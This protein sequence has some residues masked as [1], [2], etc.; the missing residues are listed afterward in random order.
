MVR[1]RRW[2]GPCPSCG[3]YFDCVP[4]MIDEETG[5]D[6]AQLG[7]DA[8][9]FNQVKPVELER[10]STGLPGFDRL[11]GEDRVSGTAGMACI[12]GHTVQIAG[13]PGSGKTTLLL[14]CAQG[15]TRS[16]RTGLYIATEESKE[17]HAAR[18]ERLGRFSSRFIMSNE[19]DLDEIFFIIE[20]Y[21]PE[22]VWVDS[23]NK[24]RLKEYKPGSKAAL[25][26]AAEDLYKF[27]Y[28]KGFGLW[29]VLQVDKSGTDF[30]GPKEIEHTVD[31]SLFM[32]KRGGIR[33]RLLVEKNRYGTA[34][35]AWQDYDLVKDAPL[36]EVPLETAADEQM[37]R[38][39]DG[40]SA[41]GGP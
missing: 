16:R 11:L 3:V 27:A 4:K 5:E 14:Q 30:V 13:E 21:S 35:P 2:L 40:R 26:V 25:A 37:E 41:A 29:L 6:T 31:T 10:V 1:A 20:K 38:Q 32:E 34:D 8:V 22:V 28:K 39:S 17:Q 7:N 24:V 33:R 12:A 36:E 19:T 23:V 18:A 9:Q 15:M